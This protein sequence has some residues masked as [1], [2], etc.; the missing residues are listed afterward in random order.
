MSVANAGHFISLNIVI[1]VFISAAGEN[2]ALGFLQDV[3]IPGSSLEDI[4]ESS[5]CIWDKYDVKFIF[6]KR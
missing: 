5:N 4:P 2:L 6:A 1:G 3:V